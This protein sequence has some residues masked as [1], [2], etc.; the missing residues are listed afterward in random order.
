M[1]IKMNQGLNISQQQGLMMTPQLQQAIKLLTLTH[2]EMTSVIAKEMEENPLLEETGGELSREEFREQQSEEL[3]H[4]EATADTFSGPELVEGGKEEFDW[5]RYIESYNNT[6]SSPSSAAD[7]NS[8]DEQPNYENMV[9]RGQSLQEHLEWQL[10]MENLTEEESKLAEEI[11]HNLDDD[12]YLPISFEDIAKASKLHLEDAHEILRM[13]QNLDPVGCATSNLSECLLIQAKALQERSPLVEAL[14]INH[15]ADI[16]A[17]DYLGMAKKLGVEVDKI[18]DAELIILSFNPKPGRLISSEEIHYVIPDIFVSEVGGEFVVNVND[19]GV[20]HLK[21]SNLY[22]SLLSKGGGATQEEKDYVMDKLRAAKW[23]IKSIET[24]QNTIFKVAKAIVK[25][26][27]NFFK[28][29]STHLKPMILKDIANE[30]GMHESTVSRV[31]TNK[32]MHTPIGT[33]EL[34]YFFNA[35]IGGK[36]GGIDIASESLKLKIKKL[37]DMEDPRK[38]L[39][40]QKIADMLKSG[41][42]VVARR[43]VAKYREGMNIPPTT[44]RK[45]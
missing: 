17:K 8:N 27:Q 5:D 1:A 40:D 23:L 39:S 30:I 7:F 25:Y 35:G 19:E 6:S 11:I 22:R 20:P 16:E 13:I 4:Q 26:Q 14:I 36:N 21:I 31:T 18:K 37:I 34:K 15:L 38:P 33:F 12:G 24:R 3:R 45:K 2:L 32:F 28:K 43:T 9:S 29:G 10:R 41:D 44:K 42:I